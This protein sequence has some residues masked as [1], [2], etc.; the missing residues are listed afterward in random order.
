MSQRTGLMARL[1]GGPPPAPEQERRRDARHTTVLQIAKLIAGDVEEL[2]IVR[3]ISTGGLKAQVYG[4]LVVGA[5]V[6]VELRTGYRADGQ[7]AWA[8]DGV[9]GMAFDHGV[10][11]LSLL[12]HCSLDDRVGTMRPPRLRVSLPG[13]LSIDGDDIPIEL[14]DVSLAGMK[15]RVARALPVDRHCRITPERMAPRAAQ[16]RWQRDGHAGIQLLDPLGFAEFA[17]WRRMLASPPAD[18]PTA[19]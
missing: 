17:A 2:C 7:I 11:V 4:D 10:S 14:S 5:A 18:G 1:R 6:T 8:D 9:I 3:D 16:I 12:T 13:L 15:V 19:D